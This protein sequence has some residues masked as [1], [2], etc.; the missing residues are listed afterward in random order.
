[1]E[2]PRRS[3]PR[4]AEIVK[5]WA[6]HPVIPLN[7]HDPEC[8]ACREGVPLWS[9]LERCHIV[10]ASDRLRPNNFVLLCA[11]CHCEAPM[12]IDRQLLIQWVRNHESWATIFYR[13]LKVALDIVEIDKLQPADFTAADHPRFNKFM[14]ARKFACHPRATRAERIKNIGWMMREYIALKKIFEGD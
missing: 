9:K 12:T 4:H 13:E 14:D 3:P 2:K 11:T 1:M 5:Y 8:F 6:E 10:A 7:P